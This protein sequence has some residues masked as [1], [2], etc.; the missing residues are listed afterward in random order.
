MEVVHHPTPSNVCLTCG[1]LLDM[2]SGTT[3]KPPAPG[4]FSLCAHCG[5]LMVWD[6]ALRLAP[7]VWEELP[8]Y[9]QTTISAYRVGLVLHGLGMN[10]EGPE[11]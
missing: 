8:E 10:P 9:I 2:A 6:D 7:T 1:A 4:D 11:A 5:D 3:A